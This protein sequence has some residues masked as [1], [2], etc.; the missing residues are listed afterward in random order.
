MFKISESETRTALARVHTSDPTKL[1]PLKQVSCLNYSKYNYSV[2]D[3]GF[4]SWN[5]VKVLQHRDLQWYGM[6]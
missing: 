6:V 4:H 2:W 3:D 5:M 1:L